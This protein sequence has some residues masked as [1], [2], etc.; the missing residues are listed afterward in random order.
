MPPL[1]SPLPD[2]DTAITASTAGGMSAAQAQTSSDTDD[3]AR[4]PVP[5]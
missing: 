2:R 5:E 3:T 4:A 1:A